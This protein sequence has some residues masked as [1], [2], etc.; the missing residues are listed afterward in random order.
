MSDDFGSGTEA[1]ALAHALR[2]RW[3]ENPQR[4]AK[5]ALGVALW[6]RQRDIARSVARH[7]RT[8]VR[9]GHKIGKSIAAVVIALWWALTRKRG[10]VVLTAPAYHQVRNI[11]WPELT[12]IYRKSRF[13]V[14]GT[15]HRNPSAGLELPG[16]RAIFCISTDKP[17]KMAG[18]SGAEILFIIDEASGFPEALWEPVFGNMAGGGR[19]LALGNPTQLSGPFYE[20]F[21][22]KR[23][24]WE[25]LH[26]SSEESPNVLAGEVVVPGLATREWVEEK[27]REWGEKSAAYQVRVAGNFPSQGDNAVIP[28]ENVQD[29]VR[30]WAE[31]AAEGLLH[32]GVDVARYGDDES[33]VQPRRGKKALEPHVFQGLDNVDLAGQVLRIVRALRHPGEKPRVK[34]D[35]VGN[36]SGVVDILRRERNELE[37][38]PINVAEAATAEGFHRLRDQLWFGCGDWLKEGGAIPDDP[39]LFSELVAPTY[40]FDARGRQEV[41]EKEAVK[42]RLRRSPDRA[43]ALCLAV[44]EKRSSMRDALAAYAARRKAA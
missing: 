34:I 43:D 37:V 10:R 35:V 12:R 2:N 24:F 16:G 26:V 40:F 19:L 42:R 44:Y 22:T 1:T 28:L 7:P 30:R 23:E 15:L 32:I 33:V 29:A 4:F 39:K 20:A 36:G 38:I 13:P 25:T 11:L 17:E 5:E 18:L 21:T 6:R 8:A 14:G 31:T 41:E 3:A 9:S 27:K